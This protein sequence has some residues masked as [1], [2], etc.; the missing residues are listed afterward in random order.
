[1]NLAFKLHPD[2]ESPIKLNTA[3][4]FK[5]IITDPNY[6]SIHYEGGGLTTLEKLNDIVSNLN[7]TKSSYYEINFSASYYNEKKELIPFLHY[8][9]SSD[10]LSFYNKAHNSGVFYSSVGELKIDNWSENISVY[11]ITEDKVK[12]IINWDNQKYNYDIDSVNNEIESLKAVIA[13]SKQKLEEKKKLSAEI[14]YTKNDV[15]KSD[16]LLNNIDVVALSKIYN[17]YL[18]LAKTTMT[19]DV[20]IKYNAVLNIQKNWNILA[21]QLGLEFIK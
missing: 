20:K 16:D 9:N 10:L 14:L 13:V 6:G 5:L 2:Y 4:Q 17:A 1:M 15:G 11:L 12:S 21:E 19:P 8:S 18:S 3:F 7:D